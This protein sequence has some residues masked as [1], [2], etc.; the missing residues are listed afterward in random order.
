MFAGSKICI[1]QFTALPFGLST[2]LVFGLAAVL[3]GE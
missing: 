1:N 2:A 3:G